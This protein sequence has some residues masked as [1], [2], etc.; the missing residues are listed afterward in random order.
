MLHRVEMTGAQ[1]VPD[2][3]VH[4]TNGNY[5]ASGAINEVW[6]EACN[7]KCAKAQVAARYPNARI[8]SVRRGLKKPLEEHHRL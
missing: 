7:D 5:R 2:Y 1:K 8:T 6:V 3:T 4:M